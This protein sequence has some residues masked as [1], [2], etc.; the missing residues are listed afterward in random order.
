L[1]KYIKAQPEGDPHE[2]DL[3]EFRLTIIGQNI[4]N[5]QS[6]CVAADIDSCQSHFHVMGFS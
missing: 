4:G 6:R 3:V 5:K 2:V 1:I